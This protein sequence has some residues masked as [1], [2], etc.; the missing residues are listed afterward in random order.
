MNR[1]KRSFVAAA[2]FCALVQA[3]GGVAGRAETGLYDR[4]MRRIRSVSG[5]EPLAGRP[6]EA[7]FSG[8]RPENL[9]GA[10]AGAENAALGIFGPKSFFPEDIKETEG[11][12][13]AL[14]DDLHLE[15]VRKLLDQFKASYPE[16][17]FDVDWKSQTV[18]AQA[19]IAWF[20]YGRR[21]VRVYGGLVRHKAI[22]AEG[23]SLVLAH[24]AGHHYGGPPIYPRSGGLSCEGRADYW[25]VKDGLRTVWRG[26]YLPKTASAIEQMGRF[27]SQKQL[28]RAW[29]APRELKA[30]GGCGHPPP[31]CRMETYRAAMD[32]RPIPECAVA[33]LA[34]ASAG[35][36]EFTK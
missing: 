26:D 3:L 31:P 32:Q 16:V 23:V 29:E 21:H 35:P 9:R 1:N 36:F 27:F 25:G 34:L 19:W 2:V 6:A 5:E 20:G 30:G 7:L 15:A 22:R 24:E 10:A 14:D 4:T 13:W 28:S 33:G 17:V 18:N 11:N 8:S 12:L